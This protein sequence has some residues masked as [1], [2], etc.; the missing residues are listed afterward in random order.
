MKLESLKTFK[1]IYIDFVTV[2]S[3]K[4][5]KNLLAWNL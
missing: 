4:L 1:E 5:K 2:Y 3:L